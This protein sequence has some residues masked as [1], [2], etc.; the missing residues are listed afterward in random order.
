[1]AKIG[2]TSVGAY[3]PYYYLD[4]ALI[5]KA[6][7]ARGAKGC[8]S[9]VNSD[10]D[11]LTMA[12]EA[13]IDCFKQVNRKRIKSLYFASVSAPYAEKSHAALLSAVCN[14]DGGVFTADVSC[15]LRS[16]TTAMKA[17]LNAALADPA[18]DH[19]VTASDNRQADPKSNAE[20]MFGAAAA[21]VTV[22]GENVIAE[23]MA[24]ASVANEINDTWRNAGETTVNFAEQRFA[25]DKGYMIS[26][27]QAVKD[28]LA[29]AGLSPD[30]V[31]K[32]VF[33]TPGVREHGTVG[34]KSGFTP[35]QIQDPLMMEV[36]DCGT[37]QPLLLLAKALET[38]APGDVI[39][40][41]AYG[42]GADAFLFKVTENIKNIQK[43]G[44][45]TV[46]KYMNRRAEFTDYAR[47]LSF[48]GH[49]MPVQGEPYKI[50]AAP[51]I[52]WRDQDVYLK[53]EA[54]KC[55]K[56]GTIAF[57]PTRV[58]YT[59]RAKD[60]NT[61]ESCI[62]HTATLFSF[63]CD[64]LAGRSDDP[65]IIQALA[66]DESGARFYLNMTDFQEAELKIGMKLEYAFRKMHDLANFPNYYWKYRPVRKIGGDEK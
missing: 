26:M 36:G 65:L 54:S 8:R 40:L 5:A 27:R 12:A 18:G 4:R 16:G 51:V 3:I 23:E 24:F 49:L 55:N 53:L 52:S 64:R 2:I 31:A 10:E 30:K 50:P 57:P 1:M 19:L 63:S 61:R 48:G 21:A 29:K 45:G 44:T 20:Q 58:C 37:A 35:E 39:L 25:I 59:C 11:S 33:A 22:G 17:A 14:L 7:G 66:N 6:W 41:A 56:C 9:I 62:D 32:A 38:A 42:N 15:A 47:F 46:T 28:V 13:A 60:D 43:A 34:A